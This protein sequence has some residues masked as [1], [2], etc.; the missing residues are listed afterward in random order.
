VRAAPCTPRR[1]VVLAEPAEPAAGRSRS[2]RSRRSRP[3]AS[4]QDPVRATLPGLRAPSDTRSRATGPPLLG[5]SG[6]PAPCRRR[7]SADAARPRRLRA[8]PPSSARALRSS[9]RRRRRSE[10]PREPTSS[11]RAG[12]APRAGRV[13]AAHGAWERTRRMRGRRATRAI[14]RRPATTPPTRPQRAR[15][16]PR[17]RSCQSQRRDAAQLPRRRAHAVLHGARRLRRG[18]GHARRVRLVAST[19]GGMPPAIRVQ[20]IGSMHR[21]GRRGRQ[22]G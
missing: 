13:T 21:E 1:S 20:I 4:V 9:A 14:A 11:R 8:S 16:V 18:Y 2:P 15:S 17:E 12:R 6:P 10:R 22:A 5:G 19:S 7:S 3:D